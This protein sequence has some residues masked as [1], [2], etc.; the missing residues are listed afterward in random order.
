MN[1]M[2]GGLWGI[3][4]VVVEDRIRKLL[5]LQLATPMRKRDFLLGT[6]RGFFRPSR[7][8]PPAL[9]FLAVFGVSTAGRCSPWSGRRGRGFSFAGV[10]TLSP[11]A[12]ARLR[13]S[14]ADQSRDRPDDRRLGGLLFH[15]PVPRTPSAA[16][17]ALP[18]TALIDGIRGVMIDG[19]PLVICSPFLVM[20][21]WGIFCFG[22][23][24][25]LP[26]E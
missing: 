22:R 18:L 12:P 11:A 4:W 14:R 6:Y 10:G 1:L 13:R 20:A 17:R 19:A 23:P 2:G 21:L 24:V 25:A 3:G 8:R 16:I 26:V 5:K 7:G 9:P 15:G